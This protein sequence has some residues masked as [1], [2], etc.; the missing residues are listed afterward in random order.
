MVNRRY[1][2]Y[3]TALLII[4]ARCSAGS[5]TAAFWQSRILPLPAEQNV[6]V[7][8]KGNKR[9]VLSALTNII[10]A[11]KHEVEDRYDCFTFSYDQA[12]MESVKKDS[13]YLA[14][15]FEITQKQA[16]LFAIIVEMSKGDEFSKSDLTRALKTNYVNLL[17]YEEDL[18]ALEK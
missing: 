8:A 9:T 3:P 5:I 16:V 6:F 13:K 15:Q 10:N 11:S 2:L 12:L 4:H 17:S 7:M 18:K 1:P 14:E